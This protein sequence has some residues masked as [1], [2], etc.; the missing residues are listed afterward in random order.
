M[1]FVT[2]KPSE[3]ILL[4]DDDPIFRRTTRKQLQDMGYP[5]VMDAETGQQAVELARRCLFDLILMDI[6]L[7]EGDDGIAAAGLIAAD[8]GTPVIFLT[9]STDAGLIERAHGVEPVGYLTKPVNK[10]SLHG[11][12]KIGLGKHRLILELRQ[13]LAKVRQLSGLLPICANCK[14]IRDDQGYWQ[15]VESYISSCSEAKFSHGICPECARILYPALFF[16]DQ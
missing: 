10:L 11:T 8:P 2:T 14:K 16:G 7:G 9:A 3:R 15:K 13:A 5:P 12:I 1:N 4:V 6:L